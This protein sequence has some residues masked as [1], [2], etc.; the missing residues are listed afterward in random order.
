MERMASVLS[1]IMLII[2]VIM[3][4]QLCMGLV[5]GEGLDL[6]VV[7]AALEFISFGVILRLLY[8]L[9]MK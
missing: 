7:M 3:I 9:S 2:G 5:F 8:K 4:L 1:A 6:E